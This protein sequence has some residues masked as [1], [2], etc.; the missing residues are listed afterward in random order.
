MP[1]LTAHARLALLLALSVLLGSVGAAGAPASVIAWDTVDPEAA[2]EALLT[3]LTN[4]TRA[5]DGLATLDVDPQLVA[6]ARW[7]SADMAE[8]DYF[9]H[10]IPPE[11]TKVFDEMAARGYCSVVSGE[12]I[13]WLAGLGLG[14]EE[15]IQ[16]LFLDSPKHRALILGE[17][18][19]VIGIGSSTRADGRQYWTVLFAQRCAT[20]G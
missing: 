16:Q 11:G 4:E 6:L 7:R 17:A 18:W 8:R 12:N 19:D 14:G 10:S 1:R 20:A 9:S 2:S 5:H 15:R 13:G 3:E